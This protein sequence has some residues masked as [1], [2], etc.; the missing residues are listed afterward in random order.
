M[1]EADDLRRRAGIEEPMSPQEVG[2][3]TALESAVEAFRNAR[4]PS[5]QVS[6]DIGEL[7]RASV[8]VE[9]LIRLM[10]QSGKLEQR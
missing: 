8:K 5:V 7:L 6:N 9:H 4:R 1:R 3:I 10:R 2:L